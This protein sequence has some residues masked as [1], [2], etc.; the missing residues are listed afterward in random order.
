MV[1]DEPQTTK[2]PMIDKEL[3]RFATPRQAEIL[4]ALQ[5]HGSSRRAA[6]ALGINDAQVRTALRRV[7][8]KAARQGYSPGNDMT[9]EAPDGFHVSKVTTLYGESGV[10]QQW[11]HRVEDKNSPEEY[12]Q[13]IAEGLLDGG[14]QAL[15]KI[16]Q[17]REL[18][19]DILSVYPLGDP[20][21]GL[22]AWAE[23]CGESFDLDIAERQ[24][25]A[26]AACLFPQAPKGSD[27]LIVD[28]GDFFHA[29][30]PL[31]RTSSGRNTVDVDTRY[32][33]VVVT[34][35][36]IQRMLI[37]AALRHHRN[38][39]V[40]CLR[41]N[42]DDR[43]T[44]TLREALKGYFHNNPRVEIDT[45]PGKFHF[46]EFGRTLLGGT[47]GDSL[48]G[49]R[50]KT[51]HEVMTED[52]GEAWGRTLHRE[53]LVGHVHHNSEAEVG[54]CIVKTYRTLAPKD[55]WHAASGYRSGRDTRLRLY[56]REWGYRG[57]H[58]APIQE[59]QKW[60]RENP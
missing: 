20:H 9:R 29:D 33:K 47:H 17:P 30:D 37:E 2:E 25:L 51:L 38:V 41:G 27:A 34:G 22:Y 35:I 40:W 7:K 44:L 55:A 54:S 1:K 5:A 23:E 28:L 39:K 46:W 31:Y 6:D 49:R 52:Q 16:P 8:I 42:H 4:E 24:Y 21:I 36:R 48:K 53:W 50:G 14:L 32:E 56:H 60:M 58:V 18:C 15:P 19:E 12:A 43:S 57:E 3:L 10:R 45:T 59:I 13:R 26:V 11:V